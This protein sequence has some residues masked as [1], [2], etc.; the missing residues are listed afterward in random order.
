MPSG[1]AYKVRLLLSHLSIPYTTTSL[2]ILATPSETRNPEFLALNPNGRIPV[3][4]VDEG[5]PLAESNAILFYLAEGTQ[6]LPDD[7]IQKAQVLQWLFFEQYSHEPYV[8]VWKYR[9]YWAPEG[10]S[11]LTDQEIRK[12]RTRGQ[13]AID[14]MEKH[15][16]GRDWFVGE[17]YSIA[18]I[19]LYAYTHAAEMIGFGVGPNV[20]A[21]LEK[22]EAVGGWVRIQKDPT[23]KN[24]F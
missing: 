1:N 18:D 10:F 13:D 16:Q 14:T 21:W 12:L 20:K 19:S 7:K 8:A 22:V 24:P 9:T 15:L 11:D 5:T 17:A 6:Y 23:G 3:L 2:N 4:V